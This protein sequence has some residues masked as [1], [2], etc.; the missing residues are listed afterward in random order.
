MASTF[1]GVA[2][3]C[4]LAPG[5]LPPTSSPPFSASS[6]G[7]GL[8]VGCQASAVV[9]SST[10]A[11]PVVA[12][13]VVA[14]SV[15]ASSKGFPGMFPPDLCMVWGGSLLPSMTVLHCVSPPRSARVPVPSCRSPGVWGSGASLHLPLRPTAVAS[16][17]SGQPASWP[18]QCCACPA[19]P[20]E[21]ALCAWLPPG[22]PLG[23]LG[24]CEPST[25]Q[26]MSNLISSWTSDNSRST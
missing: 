3:L 10:A 13:S 17:L 21:R 7:G 23:V 26:T 6:F 2:A 12:S 11:S 19:R 18:H 16:T 25:S 14:S 9:A 15:V 22:L 24:H 8:G 5:K 1:E 20:A 4:R